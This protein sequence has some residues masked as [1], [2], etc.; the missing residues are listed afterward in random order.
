MKKEC[1][2]IENSGGVK[3]IP[4]RRTIFFRMLWLSWLGIIFTV[5]VFVFATIPYQKTQLRKEMDMQAG[6]AF[7]SVSQIAESS[8]ILGD[9]SVIVDH[10]LTLIQN[11]DRVLYV[12]LTKNDGFSLIH[13]AEGWTQKTL[14]GK[15]LP[16]NEKP[17]GEGRFEW[18]E[19]VKH[20]VYHASFPFRYSGIDWGWIHIGLLPNKFYADLKSLYIRIALTAILAISVGMVASFYVARQISGPVMLL[21]RVVKQIRSGDLSARARIQS[22]D[23]VESLARSF[24]RMAAHLNTEIK[25]KEFEISERRAAEVALRES[26]KRYR[27]II[28]NIED[29]Y[30]EVDD[31]GTIIFVNE[32]MCRI[33]G[34]SSKE[35]IGMHTREIMPEAAWNKVSRKFMR[36][37][38]SGR[39]VSVF[40]L[41]IRRKDREPRQM[42]T[43]ISLIQNLA[44]KKI[45]FRGVARDVN[46]R[47][48]QEEQ[49]VYIAYH[50]TLT[51]LK[52]RKWFYENL[53]SLM[54]HA[55]RYQYQ[56]ALL[57]IDLDKF[58]K[59]NDE[60][61]HEAG[62]LL[63]REVAE[64]LRSCLR[65]TDS[66]ARIGGDEFAVIMSS[67][68]EKLLPEVVAKKIVESVRRPY[69]IYDMEVDY[70]SASIGVGVF[71]EDAADP[72]GLIKIADSAMYRAKVKRNCY[73][74]S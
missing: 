31:E 64:R 25:E 7:S 17:P 69:K 51:G 19:I 20:E 32:V 24:N 36:V 44:G 47:K 73:V 30:Y 14:E 42:E 74:S 49:L 46:E 71:P 67:P 11:N 38:L 15:W 41:E 8:I 34:Y 55:R 48:Q 50:D 10:C 72:E 40:G 5:I 18:S 9:Y 60:M 57:Y 3:K 45:G 28:E 59:V 27:M 43:S 12:V 37:F 13:T 29:G 62:D 23:E 70:I 2:K 4:R 53:N 21:D 6:V 63:L 35:L 1:E 54:D 58:K 26:E 16:G 66:I 68:Q 39:P 65:R 52:N 61:G 22:G 56:I 33:L